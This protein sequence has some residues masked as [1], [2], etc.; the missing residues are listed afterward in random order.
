MTDLNREF[1]INR[2]LEKILAP[3]RREFL[4]QLFSGE[5]GWQKFLTIM[6]ARKGARE[7]M[8]NTPTIR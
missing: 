4:R 3:E 7:A 2:E 5:D 6:L 1:W 8:S